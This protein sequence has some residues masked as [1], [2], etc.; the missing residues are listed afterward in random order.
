MPTRSPI[1]G[2]LRRLL[3]DDDGPTAT[4]YAVLAALI[5]FA[6]VAAIGLLADW[7]NATFLF[8]AGEIEVY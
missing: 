5:V 7:M 2:T 1:I 6:C 4:E 8:L 3:R